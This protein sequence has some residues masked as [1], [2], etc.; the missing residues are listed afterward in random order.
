MEDRAVGRE[1]GTVNEKWW[2]RQISDG[3]RRLVNMKAG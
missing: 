2:P 1:A 3:A